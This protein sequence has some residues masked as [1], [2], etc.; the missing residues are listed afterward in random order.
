MK[1]AIA[2]VSNGNFRIAEEGFTALDSA[3]ARFHHICE[4]MWNASDVETG[5]VMVVNERLECMNNYRE[6][7]KWGSQVVQA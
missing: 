3:I 7:I 5:C 1:Y 2:V 4:T 6:L